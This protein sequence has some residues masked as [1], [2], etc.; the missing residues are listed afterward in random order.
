MGKS[1][2]HIHSSVFD[3][4]NNY[5][6]PGN[7]RELKNLIERAVIVCKGKELLPE[8][9]T[10]INLMHNSLN[11]AFES[12][13]TFDLKELEKQTIITVLQ[14]VNFNKAEAARLLNLEWNA[15]YRRI[16]KYNIEFPE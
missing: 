6:F 4:F 2:S 1:I 12:N 7:I 11:Q 9:F 3:L 5:A 14:K 13:K 15:L 10:T 16:T 8:H